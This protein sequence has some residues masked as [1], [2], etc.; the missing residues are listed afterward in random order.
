M[1][2][3]ASL[4]KWYDNKK[5]AF[6]IGVDEFPIGGSHDYGP[7]KKKWDTF[8]WYRSGNDFWSLYWKPILDKL[9]WIK[10]SMGWVPCHTSFL[11]AIKYT[12]RAC[13]VFKGRKK[14]D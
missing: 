12:F 6:A 13:M 3:E 14:M 10:Y 1:I 2:Q 4:T 9:P 7:S 5:V 8:Y 11:N